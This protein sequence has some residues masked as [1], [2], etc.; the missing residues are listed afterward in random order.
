MCAEVKTQILP[1]K[2]LFRLS[3]P[4]RNHNCLHW[5]GKAGSGFR[6]ADLCRVS[7]AR[8]CAHTRPVNVCDTECVQS[9]SWYVWGTLVERDL[10][11]D[12]GCPYACRPSSM[13][14][15]CA[16]GVRDAVG[17]WWHQRDSGGSVWEKR[18][19]IQTHVPLLCLHN[20]SLSAPTFSP[21]DHCSCLV[22]SHHLSFP[23]SCSRS[24]S[25][26]LTF[27]P[28]FLSPL[29]PSSHLDLIDR[30]NS[31]WAIKASLSLHVCVCDVFMSVRLAKRGRH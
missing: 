11:K 1:F 9:P 28:L 24:P 27:L 7:L 10:K 20:I 25:V 23:L 22:P 16:M 15:V 4:C 2:E 19:I 5:E 21:W 29:L 26:L 8:T 17:M 31:H 13:A 14:N 3:P 18:R 12:D 30:V 6:E